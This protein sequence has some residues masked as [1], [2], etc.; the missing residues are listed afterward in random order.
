[1]S[2]TYILTIY[3]VETGGKGV[4]IFFRDFSRLSYIIYIH[5]GTIEMRPSKTVFNPITQETLTVTEA[6]HRIGISPS[7]MRRRL[8]DP[9]WTVE[10]ALTTKSDW[11][12]AKNSRSREPVAMVTTIKIPTIYIRE[13]KSPNSLIKE[14]LKKATK[15]K[16]VK[17]PLPEPSRR[18]R[19]ALTEKEVAKLTLLMDKNNLRSLTEICVALLH[20]Y[21]QENN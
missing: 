15:I 4:E 21:S 7:T 20:K 13:G 11:S 17:P 6:A 16:P 18:V 5:L 14:A 9:A 2:F 8:L 19:V 10:R 3:H 12:R 1:M